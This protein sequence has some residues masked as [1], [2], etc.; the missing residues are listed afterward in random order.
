MPVTPTECDDG[1]R[2]SACVMKCIRI[3][4]TSRVIRIID[5]HSASGAQRRE[6]LSIVMRGMVIV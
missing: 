3:L 6:F 2:H 4:Q 1:P 5:I